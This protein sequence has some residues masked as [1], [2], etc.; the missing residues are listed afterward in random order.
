MA[1]VEL[2]SGDWINADD[3]FRKTYMEAEK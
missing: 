1:F 2:E 3:I